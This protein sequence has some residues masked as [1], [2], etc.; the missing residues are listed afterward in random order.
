MSPK[1]YKKQ[2]K[3][4]QGQE[5]G[6]LISDQKKELL[7]ELETQD[8]LFQK[9]KAN[10]GKGWRKHRLTLL[11]ARLS[12]LDKLKDDCLKSRSKLLAI[13]DADDSSFSV[14]LNAYHACFHDY[15]FIAQRLLNIMKPLQ[16]EIDDLDKAPEEESDNF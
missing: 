16:E 12:K 5:A 2:A 4:P 3:K 7:A 8:Q 11:K 14:E 6:G 9:L 10:K 13:Y 15:A 1:I